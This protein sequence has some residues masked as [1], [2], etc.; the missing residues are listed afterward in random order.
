M[1]G[2]D[3]GWEQNHWYFILAVNIRVVSIMN[4][5]NGVSIVNK[6]PRLHSAF[7][8]CS[9]DANKNQTTHVLIY[10]DVFLIWKLNKGGAYFYC[11]SARVHA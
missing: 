5:L 7:P 4:Y 6:V 11:D 2:F 9:N 3:N 10:M 8:G 1:Y